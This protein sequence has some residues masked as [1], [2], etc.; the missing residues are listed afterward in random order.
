MNGDEVVGIYPPLWT[1]GPEIGERHRG[2]VPV[3]DAYELQLDFR[4]QLSS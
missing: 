1:K 2:V 3:L 4:R